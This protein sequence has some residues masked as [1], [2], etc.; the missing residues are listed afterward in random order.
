MNDKTNVI[1]L[2]RQWNEPNYMVVNSDGM[3]IEIRYLRHAL[4]N[5]NAACIIFMKQISYLSTLTDDRFK[6]D[7][8]ADNISINSETLQRIGPRA[9]CMRTCCIAWYGTHTHK[10]N[11]SAQAKLTMN[12]VVTLRFFLSRM[13]VRM[14]SMF[15]TTPMRKAN[16]DITIVGMNCGA[17]TQAFLS[18]SISPG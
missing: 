17:N 15:P 12:E 14:T 18:S 4:C 6:I 7:A 1:V 16:A 11:M 5:N 8:T 13:T 9:Q 2:I 10:N 3:C